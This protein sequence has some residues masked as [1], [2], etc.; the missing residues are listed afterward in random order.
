MVLDIKLFLGVVVHFEATKKL[1]E[2]PKVKNTFVQYVYKLWYF[3]LGGFARFGGTYCLCLQGYKV[4]Q[5]DAELTGWLETNTL[6][7][8]QRTGYTLCTL[9]TYVASRINL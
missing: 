4:G 9:M 8:Y 1:C 6:F 2:V 3:F 5:V 7:V